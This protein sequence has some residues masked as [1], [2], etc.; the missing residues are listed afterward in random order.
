MKYNSFP[1]VPRKGTIPFLP[2]LIHLL[3]VTGFPSVI[4]N[5]VW[6]T[7]DNSTTFTDGSTYSTNLNLVINDLFLN[8]PQTSGFNTSSRGQSPNRVYGLLQCTGDIPAVECSDCAVEANRSVRQLC[9]ND[10]GGRIWLDECF[11]RYHNSNFISTLDTSKAPTV[12]NLDTVTGE[13]FKFTSS[14]LVSNLSSRAYIPANN[15]FAAGS[16]NYS[17]SG[18]L[19]GLVQCWGDISIQDCRLCLFQAKT[20]LQNCCYSN[21]GAR[22]NYGSCKVRF[23][24]SPFLGSYQSPSLSPEGST[25]NT[26]T[27]PAVSTPAAAPPVAH[28]P[29][30]VN[31][32]W[33]TSEEKTSKHYP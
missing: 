15:G 11:L 28:S 16:A 26:S 30:M 7:C 6:H 21:K 3:F 2:S 14:S 10:I 24:T 29:N 23:E 32:T 13:A 20:E 18:E 17:A 33:T 5:Y 8:A 4:C 25:T 9:S 12:S 22:V 31:G 19:Y 1:S 27:P